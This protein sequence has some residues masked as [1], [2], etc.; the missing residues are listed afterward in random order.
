MVETFG[1]IAES[2]RLAVRKKIRKIIQKGSI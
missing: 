2:D 1:K